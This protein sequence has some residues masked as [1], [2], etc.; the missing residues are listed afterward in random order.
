MATSDYECAADKL[1]Q[2]ASSSLRQKEALIERLIGTLGWCGH[3]PSHAHV[4]RSY[5]RDQTW[6][7]RGDQRL[8]LVEV[9]WP[10][11][12]SDDR[13]ISLSYTLY[14]APLTPSL[15]DWCRQ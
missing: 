12:G 3:W 5:N 9:C 1:T 14:V 4:E 6:L 13:T 2:A 10:E 7:M 8:A 11:L 15:E